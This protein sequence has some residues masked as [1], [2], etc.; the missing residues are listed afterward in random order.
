LRIFEKYPEIHAENTTGGYYNYWL[1]GYEDLTSIS[2]PLVLKQY[3]IRFSIFKIMPLVF[4][5]LIYDRGSWL[6]A[7]QTGVSQTTLDN[8]SALYVLPD[9][10]RIS[11]DSVNTLTIMVN[12]L[13]HDPAFFEAPDY[14]PAA[15][16]TDM[17]SGPF[18]HQSSYHANI[19]AYLLLGKWF[20]FLKEN[21][22][23]DNTRIIIVSDHGR[24]LWDELQNNITL[25]NGE[26]LELYNALLMIKDFNAGEDLVTNNTFMT[27]ADVPLLATDGLIANPVNPFTRAPLRSGKENGVTITTSSL[28]NPT[29]QK[30]YAFKIKDSE[31]LHVREDIFDPENWESVER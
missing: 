5:N 23:Y 18:A 2:I 21:E 31:W 24:D 14:I 8:Y 29:Q 26:C 6:G 20:D 15:T 17:G 3:L 11:G 22:V 13:T 28:W 12:N 16:I 27:N 4:R 30:K 25:P 9:I 10:T 1:H 7:E 19:A